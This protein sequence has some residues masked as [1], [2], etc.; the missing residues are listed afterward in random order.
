LLNK[1][2]TSHRE[3]GNRLGANLEASHRKILAIFDKAIESFK[4][5]SPHIGDQEKV[6]DQELQPYVG[7]VD[8]LENGQID[9]ADESQIAEFSNPDHT[10]VILNAEHKLIEEICVGNSNSDEVK[11]KE[12]M[13]K[14]K[15]VSS[16]LLISLTRKKKL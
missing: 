11:A 12:I 15:E 14:C 16:L 13:A 4:I 8:L 6:S 7:I 10:D 2:E 9:L 3:L 1:I 5:T